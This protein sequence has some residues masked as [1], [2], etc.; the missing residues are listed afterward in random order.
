MIRPDEERHLFQ[1]QGTR[2]PIQGLHKQGEE[3]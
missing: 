1:V 3:A 2:E